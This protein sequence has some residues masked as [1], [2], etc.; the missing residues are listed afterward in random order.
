M[1]DKKVIE[2]NMGGGLY[3]CQY[4]WPDCKIQAGG[5]GVV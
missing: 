5:N 1:M 3:T 4:D 2:L